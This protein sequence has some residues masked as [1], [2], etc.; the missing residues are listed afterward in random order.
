MT[1]PF[2]VNK[3]DVRCVFELMQF[4]Y[5]ENSASRGG[6]IYI[7]SVNGELR[8]FNVNISNNFASGYGGDGV[9]HILTTFRC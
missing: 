7:G 4:V 2:Q 9:D 3:I 5:A 8:F 6:G 1:A